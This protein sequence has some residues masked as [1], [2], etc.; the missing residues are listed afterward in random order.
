MEEN[1]QVQYVND[2]RCKQRPDMP[3]LCLH[4]PVGLPGFFEQILVYHSAPLH[5]M[6]RYGGNTD[7]QQPVIPVHTQGISRIFLTGIAVKVHD[8]RSCI[9]LVPRQPISKPLFPALPHG[10]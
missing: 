4:N 7:R 3:G 10:S 9:T 8:T 5:F 2:V 6:M 1:I